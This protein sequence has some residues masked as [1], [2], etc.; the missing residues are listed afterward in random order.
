MSA[1]L[2]AIVLGGSGYVAGELLRLVH[3]HPRLTLGAAVSTSQAGEPLGAAFG[4]L[5]GSYP[6]AVFSTLDDAL[7]RLGSAP[8]WALLS[9]A[10]H[11]AAANM[12]AQVLDAAAA[13]G[14][15]VTAVDASADFRF[16]DPAA[17]AAVYGHPHPQP[18]L[19]AR[20]TCAL[21][22][23][24]AAID[25]PHA[26]HPGCFVTTM[27]LGIVP[28]VAAGLAEDEF[29]VS[30]VT[31]STGA[32]RSPRDTTH[33]P[34]RSGNLFAYQALKHRHG[35][36]VRALVQAAT[37]R[38]VGLHFVP[39]SGPFARGIHA[40]IFARQRTRVTES[41]VR[42]A[43]AEFYRGA[44]F[45]RVEAAP[46]RLKDVVASNYA[47]L[48]AAV[49]GD[50]IVVCAVLDNLVKGAAGG[51]IQWLNRL[52]GWPEDTGLATPPPGWC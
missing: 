22:E 47:A 8:A 28:L 31:G 52:L 12:I 18:E 16:A 39:H 26:A 46:P 40:T 25:T 34:F 45:V 14:V 42:E 9:G 21:P 35:P 2:P 33:H 51:C 48:S 6:D 20:F 3:A 23:H 43:L 44:R 10:P 32:G 24:R 17:F 1:P 36:E 27:L 38:E 41:D 30:A 15:A 4:H 29:Y 19:L 37:G 7:A 11:G 49:D 5:A 13:A 50:S